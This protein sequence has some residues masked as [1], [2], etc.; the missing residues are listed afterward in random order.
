MPRTGPLRTV[1]RRFVK[2][3]RTAHGTVVVEIDR[4]GDLHYSEILECGH[5]IDL[6]I[7]V[8]AGLHSSEW[9]DNATRRRCDICASVAGKKYA[10]IVVNALPED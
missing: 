10:E 8:R 5:E 7:L 3:S 6:P 4:L 1:T 2:V 9:G